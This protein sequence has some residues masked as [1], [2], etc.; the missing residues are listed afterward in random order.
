M[1]RLARVAGIDEQK[2]LLDLCVMRTTGSAQSVWKKLAE[3]V[4]H[5][6]LILFMLGTV[7]LPAAAAEVSHDNTDTVYYGKYG[8]IFKRG[9]SEVFQVR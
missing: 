8:V 2:A 3:R 9:G 5:A 4:T 1:I 6:A 7:S